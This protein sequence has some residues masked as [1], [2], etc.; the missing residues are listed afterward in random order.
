M[1]KI[2]QYEFK[3][4][5]NITPETDN[6]GN[7]IEYSPQE[8]TQKQNV[9]LHEYGRPFC[10]SKSQIVGLVKKASIA[11]ISDDQLV[12]VGECRPSKTI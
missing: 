6:N 4:V 9:E 10:N 12:Y 1:L 7:I 5:C 11:Y 8:C 2:D 3:Y